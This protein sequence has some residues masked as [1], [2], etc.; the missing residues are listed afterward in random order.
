[1]RIHADVWICNANKPLD[2]WIRMM[3]KPI[4]WGVAWPKPLHSGYGYLSS[5]LA[6]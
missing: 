4:Q 5:A 6:R 2:N 1:M 3:G